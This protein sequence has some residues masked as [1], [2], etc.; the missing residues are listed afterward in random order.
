MTLTMIPDLLPHGARPVV[1]L[2]QADVVDVA[3]LLVMN[4]EA[5]MKK[6]GP[7]GSVGQS[8]SRHSMSATCGPRDIISLVTPSLGPLEPIRLASLSDFGLVL[9]TLPRSQP[10]LNSQALLTTLFPS[11]LPA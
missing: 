10:T 5:L 3:L 11:S 8:G 2:D 4:D 1:F 9:I 6:R 7:P